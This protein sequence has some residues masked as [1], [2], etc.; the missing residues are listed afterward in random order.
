MYS[1]WN[2]QDPEIPGSAGIISGRA[3]LFTTQKSLTANPAAPSEL[4]VIRSGSNNVLTW[5][6]VTED[7]LGNP[8]TVDGYKVYGGATP[9]VTMETGTYLGSTASTTYTDTAGLTR[10]I[11]FYVVQAYVNP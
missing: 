3:I 9:D 2:Q 4:T 7:E 1:Y 8:I 11:Y 6:P 10:D 5:N